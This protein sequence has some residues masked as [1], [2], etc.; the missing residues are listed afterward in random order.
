MPR[1]SGLGQPYMITIWTGMRSMRIR[2]GWITLNSKTPL[3]V[4]YPLRF[5]LLT[6]EPDSLFFFPMQFWWIERA[7]FSF[8]SNHKNTEGAPG[9]VLEPGSCG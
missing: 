7:T 1:I 8:F 6:G 3:G 5:C 9:S 2:G 4:A